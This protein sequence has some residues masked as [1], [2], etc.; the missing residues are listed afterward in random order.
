MT[1]IDRPL[2]FPGTPAMI[3][4]NRRTHNWDAFGR[5]YDC[6]CKDHGTVAEWPCGADVPRETVSGAACAYVADMAGDRASVYTHPQ[7]YTVFV[8]DEHD[9]S[10]TFSNHR[11]PKPITLNLTPEQFTEM[12]WNVIEVGFSK[13]P[14]H[15]FS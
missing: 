3:L 10:I 9:R 4:A 12:I 5:C 7:S 11:L 14:L 1:T 15:D 6:D 8:A 13:V 2:R